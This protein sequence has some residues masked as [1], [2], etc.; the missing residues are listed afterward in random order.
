MRRSR[1]EDCFFKPRNHRITSLA[2]QF[3][4]SFE[5]THIVECARG[6]FPDA[7]ERMRKALNARRFMVDVSQANRFIG[8]R[9]VFR[10]TR[11]P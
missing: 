8:Q 9:S 2:S 6:R 7:A 3:S 1:G 4:S 10:A 5:T 11:P